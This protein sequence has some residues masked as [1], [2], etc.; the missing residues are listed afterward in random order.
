VGKEDGRNNS[1]M[2]GLADGN[3]AIPPA[4]YQS[5]ARAGVYLRIHSADRRSHRV[6]RVVAGV[7][8]AESRL[9]C[10]RPARHRTIQRCAGLGGSGTP[11]LQPRQRRPDISVMPVRRLLHGRARIRLRSYIRRN[12]VEQAHLAIFIRRRRRARFRVLPDRQILHGRRSARFIRL[13]VQW[14]HVEFCS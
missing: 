8:R 5:P 9:P 11:R 1:R 13:P 2:P 7:I 6:Q 3:V 12:Q 14:Q 4:S 10:K